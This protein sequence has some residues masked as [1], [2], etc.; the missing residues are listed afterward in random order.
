MQA[1]LT[2]S[3]AARNVT[4]SRYRI[5]TPGAR[6][7]VDC[8][9]YQ[10]HHFLYRNWEPFRAD[11]AELKAVL[12]THAHLDHCGRLPKLVADG[13]RGRI[14]TTPAT[15][16]I[17]EIILQDSAKL[18]EEDAAYKKKRHLREGRRGPFPEVPLYTMKDVEKTLPL[19]ETVEYDTPVEIGPGVTASFR[20]AG[21]VLGSSMIRLVFDAG[22]ASR[23]L[24]FSGDLGR[25]NRPILEDP[26]PLVAPDYVVMESTYG[27]RTH[28]DPHDIPAQLAEIINATVK[29]GGHVVIPSFALQRAQ[30]ILY[31]LNGLLLD[32]KIKP[33]DVYLDSPMAIRV[34]EVFKRHHELF[35]ADMQKLLDARH[36]PFDFPGL[37]MTQTTDESKE[38]NFLKKSAVIIAGSGMCTGGRIKH[39]LANNISRPESTVLFV[40]YQADNT[41]GRHIIGGAASVR[42][43]GQPHPVRARIEQM[44]GFS[45]HADR[46]DLLRWLSTLKSKPRRVFITHGEEKAAEHFARYLA[47][48]TGYDTLVPHYAETVRLD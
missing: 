44:G 9:M 13:F 4:G 18:Q 47:E 36:S 25:W 6:F 46:D 21:H 41:L 42:I 1:T 28:G 34:T 19:F 23:T 30:E 5:E 33:I 31:Y 20:D 26:E 3:G 24:V 39:H 45:A 8:G 40:G 14:I 29:A 11:P 10:E 7:L 2:F 15:A 16:D 22:A 38:L 35:D 48:K 32:G 43:F 12:V 17:T 37:R 27:D